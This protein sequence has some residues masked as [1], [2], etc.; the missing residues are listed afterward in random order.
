M[1]NGAV[2]ND[3]REHQPAFQKKMTIVSS[4]AMEEGQRGQGFLSVLGAAKKPCAEVCLV[5]EY[6]EQAAVADDTNVI[7]WL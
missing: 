4:V 1:P 3:D 7:I 2:Q 6:K 5:A